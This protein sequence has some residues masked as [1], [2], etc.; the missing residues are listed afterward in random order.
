MFQ[1]TAVVEQ[2]PSAKRVRSNGFW[3]TF[4][5]GWTVSVTWAPGTY[6]ANR[7][8]TFMEAFAKKDLSSKDAEIAAW[9]EDDTMWWDFDGKKPIKSGGYV[10]GWVKPDELIGYMQEVSEIALDVITA[11]EY[12]YLNKE[13]V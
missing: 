5:N 13:E 4:E 10:K 12:E 7:G 8:M 2:D 9:N 1:C 6:N 3:I 11:S